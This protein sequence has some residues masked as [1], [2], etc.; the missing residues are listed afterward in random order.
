MY[1]HVCVWW[2]NRCVLG[3]SQKA[4]GEQ[5]KSCSIAL[6]L[7]ALDGL[8]LSLKILWWSS[9][10]SPSE[11][12]II[13]PIMLVL[14]AGAAIPGLL[15]ECKLK[16]RFSCLYSK[17]THLIVLYFF[18]NI[19]LYYLCGVSTMWQTICVLTVKTKTLLRVVRIKGGRHICQILSRRPCWDVGRSLRIS[20]ELSEKDYPNHNLQQ[21][22]L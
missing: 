22:P 6:F 15:H 20:N 3:H 1:V 14:Q 17:L 5:Q 16:F 9:G 10:P 4:K 13:S 18:K 7:F 21:R 19:L 2:L 12:P 11:L 8:S